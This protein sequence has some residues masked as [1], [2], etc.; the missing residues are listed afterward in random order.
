VGVAR[1]SSGNTEPSTTD[2]KLDILLS[3]FAG[4]RADMDGQFASL[5]ADTASLRADTDRQFASLRAD[6]QGLNKVTA[7]LCKDVGKVRE[8]QGV[9]TEIAVDKALTDKYGTNLQPQLELKNMDSVLRI[10]QPE[11][12]PGSLTLGRH[13]ATT[14]LLCNVRRVLSSLPCA[15]TQLHRLPQPPGPV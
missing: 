4:L 14:A 5:R 1:P 8:L 12:L 2:E 10:I 6:V 15:C 7:Q 9:L 3:Q 13:A 11:S